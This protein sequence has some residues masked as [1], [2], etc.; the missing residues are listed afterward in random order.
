MSVEI[1]IFIFSL[2]DSIVLLFFAVFY[3]SSSLSTIFLGLLSFLSAFS[4]LFT[5]NFKFGTFRTLKR[6]FVDVEGIWD[7]VH[8]V[9][10][11][12]QNR[13]FCG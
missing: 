11:G 13:Q 3:V 4:N 2:I 10:T 1:G 9:H 12:A 5:D 6:S 7:K 8:G